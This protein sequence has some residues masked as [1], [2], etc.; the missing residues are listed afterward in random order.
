[1]WKK[2]SEILAPLTALTS[3][4]VKWKW[5]DAEQKGFDTM[6]RI[7]ARETIL[8]YPNFNKPFEIH[9]MQVNT[10]W[11]HASHKME[12][13]LLSIPESYLHPNLG[14]QLLKGNYY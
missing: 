9:Q 2:C 4:K 14:I 7:M 8:A 6:K 5:G 3:A 1:M 13:Q 11:V 12:N 10:N